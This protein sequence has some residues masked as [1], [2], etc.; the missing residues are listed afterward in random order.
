MIFKR[1]NDFLVEHFLFKGDYDRYDNYF[2][3][4]EDIKKT[5][6]NVDTEIK[7]FISRFK[8]IDYTKI[9]FSNS[10]YNDND[11]FEIIFPIE[12]DTLINPFKNLLIEIEDKNNELYYTIINTYFRGNNPNFSFDVEIERDNFNKFHFPVDLPV[13]FRNLGL[14]KKIIKAT[15]NKFDYLLFTKEE[16]SFELKTTVH[17]I[18]EMKDVFS[19]MKEQNILIFKDD[20]DLIKTI[21]PTFFIDDYNDK[22]TLD[23]DF[24]IKY[25]EEIT[26]DEFLSELYKNKL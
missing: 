19:F 15:I 20:F 3:D 24:F 10:K 14:G 2:E 13:I 7:L 6:K 18:T 9:K 16:D 11:N 5:L 25:K 23:E 1:Y 8:K 26:K 12:I 21:L 22:Y 4:V 17:S